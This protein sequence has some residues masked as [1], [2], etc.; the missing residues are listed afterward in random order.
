[1]GTQVFYLYG[2]CWGAADSS[3]DKAMQRLHTAIITRQ[4]SFLILVIIYY[5]SKHSCVHTTVLWRVEDTKHL[6]EH[7]RRRGGWG[8]VYRQSFHA[9]LK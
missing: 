5:R 2:I 1:M 9:S 3:C 4:V 8:D 7:M 6:S